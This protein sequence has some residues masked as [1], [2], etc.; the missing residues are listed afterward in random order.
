MLVLK[1]LVK[2]KLQQ[3]VSPNTTLCTY[4]RLITAGPTTC[5]IIIIIIIHSRIPLTHVIASL[6]LYLFVGRKEESKEAKMSVRL[7]VGSKDAGG[8]I[9][10]GGAIVKKLRGPLTIASIRPSF[11]G[12][13]LIDPLNK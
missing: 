11:F 7:L 2:P 4:H 9:G 5:I 3:L 8:L 12:I 13:I 10:K 6:C 1:T